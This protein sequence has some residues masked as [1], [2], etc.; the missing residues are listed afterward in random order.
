MDI[1]IA[2]IGRMKRGPELELLEHYTERLRGIGRGQGV[3]GVHLHETPESRR[4]SVAERKAEEMAALTGA[5][6]GLLIALDEGGKAMSSRDF[7][8]QIGRWRDEGAP[9]LSFL[10]GG[11]DGLDRAI[12]QQCALT[13]SLGAM[14]FPHQIARVLL[15]EQLYRAFAILANHPYHRE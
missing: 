4:K 7:A 3:S 2:A 14:T 6:K 13:L 5:G 10:I 8:R 9:A 15:A 11:P 1:I 12:R